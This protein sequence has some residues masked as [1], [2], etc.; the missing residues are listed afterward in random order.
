MPMSS[1]YPTL[2]ENL[3]FYLIHSCLPI[4]PSFIPFEIVFKDY[5]L[6]HKQQEYTKNNKILTMYLISKSFLKSHLLILEGE[7]ESVSGEEGQRE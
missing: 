5:D 7:W 4:I 1:L 3:S 6:F 2:L